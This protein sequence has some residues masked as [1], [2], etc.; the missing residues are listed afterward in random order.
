LLKELDEGLDVGDISNVEWGG[1]VRY[2]LLT[3][4]RLI[5]EFL[6]L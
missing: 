4:W 5:V 1:G 2:G 3:G 6:I